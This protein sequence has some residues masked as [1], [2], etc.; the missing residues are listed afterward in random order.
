MVDLCASTE[1][2]TT[3]EAR[4][5][6]VQFLPPAED[7]FVGTEASRL[8]GEHIAGLR[9]IRRW[10]AGNLQEARVMLPHIS[11]SFQG[12]VVAGRRQRLSTDD[13]ERVRRYDQDFPGITV[14]TYDWI[15][16]AAAKHS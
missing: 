13:I 9:E 14:R 8:L 3:G 6:L 10:I 11:N 1:R 15:I 4:W 7:L 2:Y 16:D 12:V 5:Q